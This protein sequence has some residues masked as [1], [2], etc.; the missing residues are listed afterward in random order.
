MRWDGVL[1]T[2]AVVVVVVSVG[3]RWAGRWA[4]CG[5]V[6]CRRVLRKM[7]VKPEDVAAKAD[8]VHWLRCQIRALEKSVHEL[9]EKHRRERLQTWRVRMRSGI[10]EVSQWIRARRREE[11]PLVK[12]C[13]TRG[14]ACT[15]IKGHWERVW[16]ETTRQQEKLPGMLVHVPRTDTE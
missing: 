16:E 7:G 5:V 10:R 15:A 2:V 8:P 12:D 11:V 14:E 6:L 4:C 13:R 1:V 3:C 9:E